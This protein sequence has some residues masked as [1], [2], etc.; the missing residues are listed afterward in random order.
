MNFQVW[1]NY[2]SD[3][4]FGE[5]SYK[6]KAVSLGYMDKN[7]LITFGVIA[8]AVAYPL[9]DQGLEERPELESYLTVEESDVKENGTKFLRYSNMTESQKQ[10]FTEELETDNNTLIPKDVR[11]QAWIENRYVKYQNNTYRV[12]VAEN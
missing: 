1:N 6:S 2:R 4:L 8:L 12:A 11:F 10:V 5:I 9:I 7:W 3:N